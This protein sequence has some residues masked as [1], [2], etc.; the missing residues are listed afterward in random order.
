MNKIIKNVRMN[1][2]L[3]A[4]KLLLPTAVLLAFFLCMVYGAFFY[5]GFNGKAL[6]LVV[7]SGLFTIVAVVAFIKKI[8]LVF[9]PLRSDVFKKFGD[10]DKLTQICDELKHT[11]EYEDNS[12]VISK[13][14]ISHPERINMLIEIEGV[15]AVHKSVHKTNFFVDYYQVVITDNYGETFNF[16]YPEDEEEKCLYVLGLLAEKCK[17]AKFGYTQEAMDYVRN[18]KATLGEDE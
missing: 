16:T 3:D 17:N 10:L 6:F 15:L 1:S 12:I 7:V 9:K 4:L 13:N 5:D 18:N 14:Y 11:K 8:I 2:L